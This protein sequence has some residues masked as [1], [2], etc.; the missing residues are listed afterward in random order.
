M[1]NRQGVNWPLEAQPWSALKARRRVVAQ[2]RDWGYGANH[3]A[4]GDVTALLVDAA[5][6][7]GG[8]RVS[9]HLAD[10][11]RQALILVLSH[12]P[13]LAVGDEA[14]LPRLAE[15]G[16]SSCGTDTAPDGRRRWAVIDL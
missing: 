10:Q 15:L 13:D 6:G 14:V 16:A 9:V 3:A 12:Q 2:L 5:V 8:T 11:N 1:T 7:D 4:A